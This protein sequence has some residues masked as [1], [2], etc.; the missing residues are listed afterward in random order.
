MKQAI[1]SIFDNVKYWLE[2]KQLLHAISP[3]HYNNKHIMIRLL[4]VTSQS[5]SEKNEAK[6]S[7]WNH[8]ITNNNM[9]DDILKNINPIILKDFEFAKRAIEKYNR[10]YIY[11]DSSLKGS[12]D[13]AM[14]AAL[15]EKYDE[16]YHRE[17]ILKFMPETFQLDSDIALAATTRNIENLQYATHL[18]S[19]KYFLLDFIKFNNDV[20]IKRKILQLINPELLQD[21][22]FVSQLGCFDDLCENFTNDTEF[23][24]HSVSNDIKILKKT[25]LFDESILKAALESDAFYNDREFTLAGIFRYIERFNNSYEELDSKIKDKTILQKLFWE[26][27][28]TLSDE[29][30]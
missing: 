28:E 14:T 21:K 11:I 5:I 10:S 22:K 15:K 3:D 24:V 12:Q 20:K 17:P 27:G 16:K 23:V 19:N 13:L 30:I 25:K 6:R 29:F 8:H 7:M 4:G 26:F 18:R 9:G 2:K 1:D